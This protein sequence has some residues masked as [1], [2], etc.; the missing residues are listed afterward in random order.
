MT[1]PKVTKAFEDGRVPKGITADYLNQ[2]RDAS[3][4]AGIVFVTALTSIIVLGRLA[5]RAF[6]MRRFGFD[7]GLTLISWM[8][9][10]AFVGLCIE[11]IKLGSG[12]HFAYIEY[13]LDMPTIE[14]TEVLDFVAHIIYTTALLLCRMSG[15]A[16]YHRLCAVHDR[17]RLGISVV[18]GILIAGYIPQLLLIVFH[19]TPVTGLWP[20]EWQR[21]FEDYTC[22]QWGL[23][24]S[25]NS[26]VS[27]ICDFLLFGIPIV[28]LRV[29]EMP[30]KRKIQL[31][32]ILL[33]GISVIAISIVRL[34]L[35]IEGQWNTDMSWA[36]D[37]M[38]AIE[39]SEIGATLIALS[40]PGFKP[41]F[42]K[43]VLQR[44]IT[45]GESNVKS[46]YEK[47]QSSKGGTA[48]RSLN[49]RPEH[50]ALTSRD[51]SAARTQVHRT[52][53][54]TADNRSEN[55]ADG[56]LVQVDFRI[57]EDIQD[58]NSTSDPERAWQ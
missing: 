25:V 14:Y 21:G 15:L 17:L 33:P 34:V 51:T 7:D 37:P 23:V 57:K 8:C 54:A 4:I 50:D 19:C 41:L 2:S 30:R 22:L 27:L 55:S 42:D 12:R 58:A 26:S 53:N 16:F 29:L 24:Y 9:F 44:D 28:M 49:F 3:A 39:V 47:Q 31:G 13:V 56:I 6:L 5:S 48:L 32:C 45:K 38:L 1:D 46:K 40:I 52:S 20:Y 43:V 10:V 35:V 36:Y 18:F 11:L